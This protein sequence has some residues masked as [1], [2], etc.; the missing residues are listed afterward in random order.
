MS[1]QKSKFNSSIY[2]YEKQENLFK[3]QKPVLEDKEEVY[4]SSILSDFHM[5]VMTALMNGLNPMSQINRENILLAA[6]SFSSHPKTFETSLLMKIASLQVNNVWNSQQ[7]HFLRQEFRLK[8]QPYLFKLSG[9]VPLEIQD[10]VIYGKNIK[11]Y[12]KISDDFLGFIAYGIKKKRKTKQGANVS[13]FMREL[14]KHGSLIFAIAKGYG[15]TLIADS[16]INDFANTF[17]QEPEKNHIM[18]FI[19]K[20]SE[21]IFPN[22]ACVAIGIK[23]PACSTLFIAGDMFVYSGKMPLHIGNEAERLGSNMQLMNGKRANQKLIKVY[24][25][26]IYEYNINTSFSISTCPLEAGFKPTVENIR[27]LSNDDNAFLM[28]Y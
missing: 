19:E 21:K 6:R 26:R 8:V 1:P 9:I 4:F 10:F 16:I 3:D 24:D 15:K 23:K 22:H 13:V 20:Q 14:K 5:C 27:K 7:S 17:K 12:D 25:L 28:F 18:H 2:Y 11:T